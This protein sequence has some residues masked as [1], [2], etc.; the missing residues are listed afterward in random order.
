[1]DDMDGASRNRNPGEELPWNDL[2]A[3]AEELAKGSRGGTL[4]DLSAENLQG[5]VNELVVYQLELQAQNANLRQKQEALLASRD[6]YFELY[7]A[8]PVGYLVLDPQGIIQEANGTAAAMLQVPPRRLLGRGLCRFVHPEDQGLFYR[9]LGHGARTGEPRALDLRMGRGA[10]EFFPAH[11]VHTVDQREGRGCLHMVVCDLSGTRGERTPRLEAPQLG[12]E[13]RKMDS[14]A[15]LARGM[16]QEINTL[17]ATIKTFLETR[18][19]QACPAPDL[20][21]DLGAAR[22]ACA[23]GRSLAFRLLGFARSNLAEERTLDL[24]A[25]VR[26]EA[27][28]LGGLGLPQRKIRLELELGEGLLPVRGDPAALACALMNICVNSLEAMP[29]GGVLDL[30]TWSE[31][32]DRVV[33]EVADTGVGMPPEVAERAADPFFTTH[34]NR[35]AAGLG[36]S[37]AY[38]VARSHRGNLEIDS[39]PGLGTSVKLHLPARSEGPGRREGVSV[40]ILPMESFRQWERALAEHPAGL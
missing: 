7:D 32:D 4:D 5:I 40:P 15:I 39:T 33:L 18:Q 8:A 2:Q 27:A 36:L 1:M 37:M 9:H 25:L 14:L 30:R 22:E 34:G 29:E 35:K 28:L 24:N 10:L 21:V 26:D 16:A 12:M 3:F 38:G 20:P 13:A 11:L 6:R 17:M 31:G 23:Q 19:D